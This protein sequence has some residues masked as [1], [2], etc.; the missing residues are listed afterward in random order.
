[1]L[2]MKKVPGSEVRGVKR[3]NESAWARNVS[4]GRKDEGKSYVSSRRK[5]VEARKTGASCR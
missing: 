1:M 3:R 5:Q 2:L 4:K